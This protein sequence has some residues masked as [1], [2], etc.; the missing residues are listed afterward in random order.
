[1]H[2]G[3]EE[4]SRYLLLWPQIEG[5]LIK[6]MHGGKVRCRCSWLKQIA[7]PGLC[8]SSSI[9]KPVLSEQKT[10]EAVQKLSSPKIIISGIWKLNGRI[11]PNRKL[12]TS[13]QCF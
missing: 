7:Q 10:M 13:N 11:S 5:L 2:S 9:L 1:M 6:V 12:K 8:P 4:L 3:E